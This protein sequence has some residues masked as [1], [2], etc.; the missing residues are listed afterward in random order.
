[1]SHQLYIISDT[2]PAS[3]STAVSAVTAGGLD[4]F[5][6]FTVDAQLVG[7]TGGTLDV[8]LQRQVALDAEVTGGVWADWLHFP[9]LSSGAGAVK[10]SAITGSSTTITVVGNATDASGATP[11]LAANTF[12]GGHPGNKLRAVYVAGTSTSAGAAV[13]IYITGWKR[14]V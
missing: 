12:V 6:W 3:A 8:Y 2:T 9:Q 10:Y 13:K 7:A 14:R 11:A 1:M 4:D 5:D